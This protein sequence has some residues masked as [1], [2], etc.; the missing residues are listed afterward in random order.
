MLVHDKFNSP[1][2]DKIFDDTIAFPYDIEL[3]NH[4]LG[5]RLNPENLEQTVEKFNIPMELLVSKI[6]E[7][8][9]SE[10]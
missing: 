1:H 10:V 5:M 7:Y 4:L 6:K 2:L 8:T 3:F 9:I